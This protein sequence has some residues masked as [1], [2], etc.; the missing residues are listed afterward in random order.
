MSK[1]MLVIAGMLAMCL[2]VGC[3]SSSGSGGSGALGG[4]W[5]GTTAG[6]PLTMILNQ[7]GTSLSGSYKLENP[8]FEENLSGTASGATAPTTAVL[9]GGAD[10]QFRITFNSENSMSGGFFKGSTQVGSVSA[11]K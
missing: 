11:T 10:R 1:L 7:N 4:T 9:S 5:R 6:R 2:A 3:E 8:D